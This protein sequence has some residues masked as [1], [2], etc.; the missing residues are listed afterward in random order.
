MPKDIRKLDYYEEKVARE[1]ITIKRVF[2]EEEV[3]EKIEHLTTE[4]DPRL[5]MLGII[6]IADSFSHELFYEELVS[7]LVHELKV[8]A[9]PPEEREEYIKQR[10]QRDA[11]INELVA[12]FEATKRRKRREKFIE[13]L[14]S[15]ELH[16]EERKL[17][18]WAKELRS[19]IEACHND[20][21][22][23][24]LEDEL[25]EIEDDMRLCARQ[26]RRLRKRTS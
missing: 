22:K 12:V 1:A 10:E 19:R 6:R 20:E 4:T 18:E 23:E 7:A 14:E 2:A 15:W 26:H 9:L 11:K 17:S 24:R 8:V 21:E 25:A 16:E 3:K 5:V 13:S